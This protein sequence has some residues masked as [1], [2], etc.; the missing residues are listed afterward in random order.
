VL[1]AFNLIELDGE[2][3]RRTPVEQR[4]GKLLRLVRDPYANSLRRVQN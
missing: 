4:K 2:D 1:C 3:L